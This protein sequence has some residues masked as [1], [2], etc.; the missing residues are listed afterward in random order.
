MRRCKDELRQER[1]S[2]AFAEVH[3]REALAMQSHG[4]V[5]MS[6]SQTK[7]MSADKIVAIGMVKDEADVIGHTIRHLIAH[8][9]DHILIADNLS[10]DQT[11]E[12][13]AGLALEFPKVVVPILDH[14]PGYY[15]ALKMTRLLQEARDRFGAEWVV[16]FDADEIFIHSRPAGETLCDL[17]RKVPVAFEAITVPMANHFPTVLNRPGEAN[18]FLRLWRRHIPANTLPKII[19]RPLPGLELQQGNHNAIIGQRVAF[20]ADTA[21]SIRHFPYRSEE[22][23]IRKCINGA[24]AYKKT[25]LPY[26]QGEHWRSYGRIFD[27][28]GEAGLIAWYKKWFYL[29]VDRIS[30][31]VLDP[32]P[33]RGIKEGVA[34]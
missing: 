30:E 13:L 28:H 15:Q 18:P 33:L 5:R 19:V 1:L 24:A 29:D 22:Q 20:A 34:K 10:S 9:V 17:I 8:G 14:E 31:T 6:V 32:V 16:P 11:P 26:S 3:Q 12:I 4:D 25:D 21:I 27:E 23:F 7:A 2:A